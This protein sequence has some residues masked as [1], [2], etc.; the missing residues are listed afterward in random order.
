MIR[1]DRLLKALSI[2]MVFTL[3]LPF[4]PLKKLAAGSKDWMLF[5]R[6][7]ELYLLDEGILIIQNE[8]VSGIDGYRLMLYDTD[9]LTKLWFHD[10][11]KYNGG[12]VTHVNIYCFQKG[13]YL[14]STQN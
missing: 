4:A 3:V 11:G 13:N 7:H 6:E 9:K 12:G 8:L 10:F 5:S 14:V 2:G 1:S